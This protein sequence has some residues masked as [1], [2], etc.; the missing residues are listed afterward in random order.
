MVTYHPGLPNLPGIL[1]DLHPILSS[2]DRCKAAIPEVPLVA[3]RRPKSLKDI[4]V[5]AKVK[6]THNSCDIVKGVSKC[7][8]RRCSVCNYIKIGKVF[9]SK[10]T[11]K[12]YSINYNFNCN[13]C[14]VVYL[15][16]CKVCG[17][18]YVGSTINRFRT[19][20]N[21]HRSRLRK[22][23]SLGVEQREADDIIYRHFNS[24]Q[25]DGIESMIVQIIDQV[26]DEKELRNKEGQW[27]YKLKTLVPNGL[28]VDDFFHSQNCKPR[29]RK[30]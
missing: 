18:Q 26:N 13:S 30:Q 29:S 5:R 28:N 15:F 20:F 25:H 22:H 10:A 3:Y 7:G 21:N 19:R 8:D 9:M 16:S 14:N 4:L 6:R 23:N 12:Q 17:I 2:S 1:K 11:G 24:S 27:A